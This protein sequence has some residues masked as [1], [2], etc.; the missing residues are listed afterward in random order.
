M[1]TKTV[2]AG[3]GDRSPI[4]GFTIVLATAGGRNLLVGFMRQ[5]ATAVGKK[6]PGI[7][8]VG[9]TEG[10][11]G[12]G[13]RKAGL[14]F[15]VCLATAFEGEPGT[16]SLGI[17]AALAG[18]GGRRKLLGFTGYLATAKEREPGRLQLGSTFRL[19]GLGERNHAKGISRPLALACGRNGLLEFIDGVATAI[20][21]MS[22]AL[23]RRAS[24]MEWPG[25][26]G[27][28]NSLGFKPNLAT[29][30]GVMAVPQSARIW[31]CACG[32]ASPRQAR[33]GF[34]IRHGGP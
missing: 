32:S 16:G 26:G 3:L 34:A 23:C 12:L 14:G 1:G 30:I 21:K 17:N 4:L 6:E 22:P 8:T 7:G 31:W 25:S 20:G 10:P 11:A 33:E 19:A 9:I 15:M 13:S 28:M 27:R 24:T 5:L 29:A 18:L 2:L